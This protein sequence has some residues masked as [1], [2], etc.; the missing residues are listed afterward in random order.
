[1]KIRKVLLEGGLEVVPSFMN[2]N[3]ITVCFLTNISQAQFH[4]FYLHSFS[5]DSEYLWSINCTKI[6]LSWS[7]H[8]QKISQNGSKNIKENKNNF[9]E[10]WATP[11]NWNW[12]SYSWSHMKFFKETTY[13]QVSIKQASLLNS[14]QYCWAS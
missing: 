5:L 1:M 12:L 13:S 6:Q 9:F 10:K 7:Y 3:L 4:F 8:F 14:I 11:E 2:N